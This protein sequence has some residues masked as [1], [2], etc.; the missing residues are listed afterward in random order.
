MT[1]NWTFVDSGTLPE[2]DPDEVARQLRAD[3][4]RRLQCICGR[5][6]KA[7][8]YRDHGMNLIGARTWS[9]V[10]S[11]CGKVTDGT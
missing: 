11:R 10:C 4:N 2:P 7:S 1:F 9:W 5:F 3:R 6:V 8:T